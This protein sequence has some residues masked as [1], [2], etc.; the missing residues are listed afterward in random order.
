MYVFVLPGYNINV[1]RILQMW[2][3]LYHI[4]TYAILRPAFSGPWAGLAKSPNICNV[5]GKNRA[6]ID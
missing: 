6:G 3:A 4:C 5:S 2:G 1:P